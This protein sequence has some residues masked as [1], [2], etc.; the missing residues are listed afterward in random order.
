MG[1]LLTI[2]LPLS[3]A[4]VMFSLGI[5]LTFEDFKRVAAR[6]FAFAV[7]AF[8]QMILLPLIGV[9]LAVAFMLPGEL[10]LGFMILALCPGGVVSNILTKLANG[11]VALSITL[12]SVISLVSIFSVPILV[13]LSA[14]AFWEVDAPVI[15]VTGLGLSMFVIT[16]V[17][18]A[19]GV[20]LRHY[21]PEF[22]QKADLPLSRVATMLFV[23]IVA[24]ALTSNWDLFIANLPKL[25]PALITLNVI[26]LAAGIASGWL[27]G[28]SHKE[29]T[30]IAI[31]SSTQNATLGITVG[32]LI[33]EQAGSFPPFSLPS[34]VYGITMYVIV[35]PFVFWRRRAD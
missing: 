31:E 19:I 10:A 6:P 3:L 13:G 8:N 1:P 9:V 26:M 17:P 16:A 24:G 18:V 34:S 33:A 4:I 22:S 30:A 27:M 12:T 35:A 5:G 29:G 25:A 28:L 7:G 14:N 21:A 20:A 15:R 32:S 2:F 11:D 23:I